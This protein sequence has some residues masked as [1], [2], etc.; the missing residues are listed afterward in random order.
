ME[1]VKDLRKIHQ[2]EAGEEE[3]AGM[4]EE[5]EELEGQ[6]GMVGKTTEEM[7]GEMME[8]TMGDGQEEEVVLQET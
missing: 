1:M 3:E 4:G 5:E 8:V 2:V 7:T 6:V